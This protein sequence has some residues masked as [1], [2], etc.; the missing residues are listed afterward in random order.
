LSWRSLGLW[1]LGYHDAALSDADRALV[2]AREMRH[3]PTLMT[4]LAIAGF[5]RILSGDYTAAS[6]Q[7]DELVALA[8][9]KGAAVWKI[10]GMLHQS[11]VVALIG[12]ASNAVQTITSGIAAWRSTG[13]TL[14]TPLYLEILTSAYT[15]LGRFNDA[16]DRIGEAI[17]MIETTHERWCE[18]EVTRTGGEL[19]R[20]SA[21]PKAVKAEA[22]LERALM[23]ARQQQA[24]SWELRASMRLA[25]L[26]RDRGNVQQAR[27]LLASV[28]RV[29][30]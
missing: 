15:D 2:H 27:E 21:T 13:T 20:L 19:A 26:W 23:V 29:V 17:G 9:E 1:L 3:A 12:E 16:W 22:Y 24:K 25:R 8:E 5:C 30:H 11:W 28:L 14:W 4:A 10:A 18:A 7:T 6:A